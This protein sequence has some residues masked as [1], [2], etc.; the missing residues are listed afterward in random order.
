VSPLAGHV[1]GIPAEEAVAALAP[2]LAAFG[3]LAVARLRAARHRL[4]HRSRSS[5]ARAR[6]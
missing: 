3:A 5:T 1:A 6:G 4:T 2:A